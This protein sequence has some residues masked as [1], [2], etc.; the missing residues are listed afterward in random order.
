MDKEMQT[1]SEIMD[2]GLISDNEML[3]IPKL[4]N[5]FIKTRQ[6]MDE[7]LAVLEKAEKLGHF[8]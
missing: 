4:K 1:L 7:N 5:Q 8:E 2:D 6:R 3:L